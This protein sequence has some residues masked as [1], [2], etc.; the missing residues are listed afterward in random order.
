MGAMLREKDWTKTKFGSMVNWPP[1]LVSMVSLLI[2]SASPMALWYGENHLVIYNDGYIPV[3]GN[4]HPTCFGESA[5]K[6]WGDEWPK[7]EPVFN[8]VMNGK[9]VDTQDS[10]VFVDRE[11]Y[12]AVCQLGD[13][14]I[15]RKHISHG[16]GIQLLANR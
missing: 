10:C 5:A 15:C 13:M 8:S 4:K 12:K 14:L 6:Y 16:P 1:S 7:M 3:A 9:S 11:G 2:N